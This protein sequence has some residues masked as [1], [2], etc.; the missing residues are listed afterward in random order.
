[1][2]YEQ[3]MNQQE[4]GGG[5]LSVDR[6]LSALRRRL[7][8]VIAMPILAAVV[9]VLFALSLPNRY[10]ASAV[11]QI[12][13][14]KKSISSFEGVLENLKA[15]G[16]VVDSEEEIIGSRLIALK[17]IDILGLRTD[18]EFSRPP[19]WQR[20]LTALGLRA[21][22]LPE[23]VPPAAELGSTVNIDPITGFLGPEKPGQTHPARDE[24]AVAFSER[25]RVTRIRKTLLLDIRFSAESAAKA[26]RIA[27]TVAEVYLAEQVKQK[28]EVTD[29]AAKLLEQKLEALRAELTEK[30]RRVARFKAENDI[31]DTEGQILGEKQ[32]AR[33]MEQT[34]IARNNTAEARAK[35]ELAQRIARDGSDFSNIADVLQSQTIR[36][37]KEQYAKATGREAELA[38]RYGSRHPDMQKVRAEV[39]E[40][41]AQIENEIGR[42]VANLQNEVQ[43]AE[44]RERELNESLAS[45]KG[46]DT[47]SKTAGVRLKE[48]QRDTDTTK[49][50]YEALLARYKQTVETQSLHL[51]DARIV[52]QADAP[53]FPASPK[54]K[55]LVVL[56]TLGGG[57]LGLMIAILLEFMTFGIGRPEDV[58]RVFELAHLAS[59]P[60]A[61]A[62]EPPRAALHEMRLMVAEPSGTFAEAIRGLRREVDVRRAH[63]G[64][65]IIQ[66]SA[67]M[68]G[69]GSGIVASNLA[70]NFALTGARVLLIDGDLRRFHLTRELA[71]TRRHGF[72][73]ALAEGFAPE[74]LILRDASTGLHFLPGAGPAPTTL[75]AAEILS[76]PSAASALARLK[77]QFDVL[78]VDSAP[79][80]PVIDGRV[81]ADY[82]DQI[83]FVMAWRRTPKQLARRALS[84]LGF[85]Q[86]K[87]VGV[88][89]N[90]I[91]QDVLADQT[92][93]MVS[94]PRSIPWP[95]TAPPSRSAA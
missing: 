93:G 39:A 11:V 61:A 19:L 31:F 83:V 81:L 38:T 50:L 47:L 5:A 78:V 16:A 14:R 92:G 36:L 68:P 85:N 72:A 49:S 77:S 28:R 56:G 9:S 35:Y 20:T 30:E 4:T 3:Q 55:Q 22:D 43:I 71:P 40:A 18:P 21:P 10:D 59:L 76:S 60:A 37:L 69:E 48:L 79:L 32:L 44:R 15:D 80:L 12:D 63:L 29:H 13:P 34:V 7:K 90:Q 82:A 89:V 33:L 2:S 87:L 65:R 51:P 67:S 26:A 70:L 64:P 53:L 24:V 45:L 25:L 73:D 41:R 95:S 75:A 23:P 86:N 52:E 74:S 88:V 6:L 62:D 91:D 84:S 54:R 27:N 94:L 1:M 66:V 46:D 58:E 57:A 8:I 17:V 42:L